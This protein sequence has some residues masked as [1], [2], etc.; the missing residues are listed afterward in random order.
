MKL[1]GKTALVTGASSGVGKAIASYFAKTGIQVVGTSR[2]PDKV[3]WPEGVRGVKFDASDW[4]SVEA[5]WAEAG[6]HESPPDIVVNNAGAGLVGEFEVIDFDDWAAQLELLLLSPMRLSQLALQ[7]WSPERP[8]ALVNVTSLAVEYAIPYLSGYNVGKAGL[9]AFCESLALEVDERSVQVLEL[10]L[11]DLD[12][13]FSR[14]IASLPDSEKARRVWET[15]CQHESRGPEPDLVAKK[16]LIALL[17]ERKGVLRVG[18]FFQTVVASI[19]GRFLSH[20][21]KRAVNL[22]YY[23]LGKD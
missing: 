13:G 7:R 14:K 6:F 16:L 4:R 18:G 1:A 2:N 20:R 9:A 11:G 5:F 22:S 23:N 21:L 8:G 12:T 17:N 10:R 3:D 19:S 15:L